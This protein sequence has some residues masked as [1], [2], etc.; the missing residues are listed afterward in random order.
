VDALE[1]AVLR[2]YSGSS[3]V[4]P[5]NLISYSF[6]DLQDMLNAGTGVLQV[7]NDLRQADWI[8]FVM[9]N[10]SVANPDSLALRQFLDQRPDLSQGKKLI[11]FSLSEPYSL[12]A[13]DISK[14]SAYYALFSRSSS[15]VEIA[16]RILFQEIQPTGDLP[17]SVP[18]IGYEILEAT[19]PDPEQV[20]PISLESPAQPALDATQIPGRSTVS[21][22]RS[23]IDF[24]PDRCHTRS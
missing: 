13:T 3:Q 9:D 4:I 2:L 15:F 8:V 21:P 23:E 6:Q 24:D 18:G 20:I 19:S 1:N 22:S 10:M 17:V 5:G 7:E 14:L 11:V 12:D 16:A